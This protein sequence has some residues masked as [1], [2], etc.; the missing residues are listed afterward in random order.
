MAFCSKAPTHAAR[1]F[2]HQRPGNVRCVC[3]GL[4]RLQLSHHQSPVTSHQSPVITSLI[5]LRCCNGEVRVSL[6]VFDGM[7][8]FTLPSGVVRQSSNL[9]CKDNW[10][11]PPAPGTAHMQNLVPLGKPGHGNSLWFMLKRS[12]VLRHNGPEDSTF[13]SKE[14]RPGLRHC[15]WAPLRNKSAGALATRNLWTL[16]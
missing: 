13:Q 9:Y 3:G 11:L 14:L 6:I 8:H 2:D 10:N 1:W 7:V 15:A 5:N 16:V 4:Q 12:T